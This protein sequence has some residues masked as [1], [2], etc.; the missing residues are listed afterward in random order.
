MVWLYLPESEGLTS[1]YSSVFPHREPGVSS[2]GKHLP[3]QSLE[4]KWKKGGFIRLLSGLMLPPSTGDLLLEKWITSVPVSHASRGV[5]PVKCKKQR[6][7]DGSGTTLSESFAKFD[8]VSYSWKTCQVSLMGELTPFLGTWPQSGSMLNGV[9]SK[10]LPLVQDITETVFSYLD[11]FQTPTLAESKN[12]PYQNSNGK[13]YPTLTGQIQMFPTPITSEAEK[14]GI[15]AFKK[16]GQSLTSLVKMGMFNTPCARDGQNSS[17]PKSHANWDSLPGDMIR[18][19]DAQNGGYLNP[20]WVEWLMGWPIGWTDLERAEMEW[21][22]SKQPS[23]IQ[24][25]SKEQLKE[26]V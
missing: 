18:S 2:R 7:K 21:Y 16:S 25:S 19:G 3:P 17:F 22:H 8:P 14:A 15:T 23:L 11:T 26:V 5:K 6:T 1:E 9:C 4:R 13:K 10:R 20:Q 24:S 12:V